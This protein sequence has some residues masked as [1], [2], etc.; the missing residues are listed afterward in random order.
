MGF[1]FRF[2]LKL[3]IRMSVCKVGNVL[4]FLAYKHLRAVMQGQCSKFLSLSRWNISKAYKD[5]YDSRAV[6][7]ILVGGEGRDNQFR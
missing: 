4:S 3:F 6:G 7:A 5:T 2:S 1:P